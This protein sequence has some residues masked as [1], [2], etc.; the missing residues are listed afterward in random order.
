MKGV[1]LAGGKGTRLLP[2]TKITNKHLLPI[3]NGAMIEYPLATLIKGGMKD[4][5]IVS[6]R[7]HAGDFVEY[8]GSGKDFGVKFSY[9]VQDEAGGIAQALLLAE[10]FADKGPITV[11]LGD[12]VFENN[13]SK[14]MKSFRNG[15]R[16]FL[17]KVPDP[18]RFGVPEL[19]GKIVTQIFEKP[20]N[21]PTPYAV[22]GLYQYDSDVF[23]IIKRL[24]PSARGE[25]EITDV[26]NA[27]IKRGKL[28]A[29]LVKGFW[30]DAGTFDSLA[31]TVEWAMK[32]SLKTKR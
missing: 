15:A 18:K 8:L 12:N 11:I 1:I 23:K 2:L 19:K 26:N 29:E 25:L 28:R 27:Y 3:F 31:K 17:K 24:K 30:S 6:G 5:L 22:T 32:K 13:F 21:P 14:N 20:A 10:D 4:I 9:K 7:E 16:I